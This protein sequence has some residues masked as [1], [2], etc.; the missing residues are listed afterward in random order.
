MFT[1][2]FLQSATEGKSDVIVSAIEFELFCGGE[3]LQIVHQGIQA[4]V[5]PAQARGIFLQ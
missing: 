2:F 3:H 4:G 1:A 5:L